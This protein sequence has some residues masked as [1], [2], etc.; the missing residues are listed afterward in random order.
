[1]LK[2]NKIITDFSQLTFLYYAWTNLFEANYV[3]LSLQ[4]KLKLYPNFLYNPEPFFGNWHYFRD[5][6]TNDDRPHWALNAFKNAI[7]ADE[8]DF[9]E[10]N[11]KAFFNLIDFWQK[12]I[13]FITYLYK[14]YVH[15]NLPFS[16]VEFTFVDLYFSMLPSMDELALFLKENNELV[17]LKTKNLNNLDYLDKIIKH[18]ISY[19]DFVN[20]FFAWSNYALKYKDKWL[21][22]SPSNK[23]KEVLLAELSSLSLD[24][25][26]YLSLNLPVTLKEHKLDADRRQENLHKTFGPILENMVKAQ[27]GEPVDPNIPLLTPVNL[28]DLLIKK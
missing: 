9:Y 4:Q 10:V 3:K 21:N 22:L 20:L 17:D 7:C 24:T 12:G 15:F 23:V 27:Q 26:S 25:L 6:D 28:A 5:L 18:I 13:T 2:N 8:Y 11:S 14:L 19:P 1:M 16:S